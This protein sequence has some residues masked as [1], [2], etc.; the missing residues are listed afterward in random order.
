MNIK[1]MFS[2]LKEKILYNLYTLVNDHMRFVVI[3]G[4]TTHPDALGDWPVSNAGITLSCRI[5]MDI[6]EDAIPNTDKKGSEYI[7]LTYKDRGQYCFSVNPDLEGYTRR[8]ILSPVMFDPQW[9]TIG[10]QPCTPSVMMML[11]E[12][13]MMTDAHVVLP[14]RIEQDTTHHCEC[15]KISNPSSVRIWWKPFSWLIWRCIFRYQDNVGKA[16]KMTK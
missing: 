16:K 10:F 6:L 11:H 13:K 9:H 5:Y 8:P 2:N 4:D 1:A 3:E 15:F 14:V 12:W 7:T